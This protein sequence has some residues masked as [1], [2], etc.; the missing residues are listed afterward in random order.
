MS[1]ESGTAG[2]R[3]SMKSLF[4]SVLPI[5]T[6]QCGHVGLEARLRRVVHPAQSPWPANVH[7]TMLMWQN[8]RERTT[9]EKSEMA[10]EFGRETSVT[11][12]S[13]I[14]RIHSAKSSNFK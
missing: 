6:R 9:T 3:N 4:P 7:Q 2:S 12:D 1:S 14:P 11:F 8:T 5:L 10:E 13:T